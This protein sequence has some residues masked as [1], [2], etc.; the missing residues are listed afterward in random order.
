MARYR[1]RN[2][3]A[4]YGTGMALARYA[5][6]NRRAIANRARQMMFSRTRTGTRNRV[7][8]GQGVTSQYDKRLIYRKRYMPRGKKRSWRK[9][10]NKVIAVSTKSLGSST[11]VRNDLI[12]SDFLLVPAAQ[13]AQNVIQLALY[14]VRSNINYLNDI[15]E[16]SGDSRLNPS[17][18]MI[19]MSG[20]LDIT[21][22]FQ[23]LLAS[24]VLTPTGNPPLSA[25]VDV[26]E[27]Q[28]NGPSG[29]SGE[30][31][32]ILECFQNGSTDT[33]TI[34]G[35]TTALDNNAR[36]WT[37]FDGNSALSQNKIKIIKKTKFFLSSEQTA[38]YQLRDPKTHVYSKD[39][40]PSTASANWQGIT[41]WIFIVWKVIPGYV[42]ADSPNNDVARLNVGFTRKYMYKINQDSTDYDMYQN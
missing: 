39:S 28:W 27:M 41:K 17:S 40:I 37:P 10:K 1:A 14:P 38:T 8:S 42:Y 36:G 9:F 7:T 16:I 2:R 4:N 15:N 22:R 3:F 33:A 6:N 35:Q 29:Q 32:N 18:K 26:Y 11:V 19:F 30:A 21:M 23:S 20:V 13:S 24:G 5:Y 12:Q 34:P 31:T 25:E